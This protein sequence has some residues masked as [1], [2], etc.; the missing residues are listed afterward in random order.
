[1]IAEGF[2]PTDPL[3]AEHLNQLLANAGLWNLFLKNIAVQTMFGSGPNGVFDFDGANTY[4]HW[5]KVGSVYTNTAYTRFAPSNMTVRSGITVKINAGYIVGGGKL[6]VEGGGVIVL[7][8]NDGAAGAPGVAGAG[9]AVVAGTGARG[10]GATGGAGGAS[11]ANG[12]NGGNVVNGVGGN[13][14]D[15]GN[16]TG[17]H[18]GGGAASGSV[19]DASVLTTYPGCVEAL[20]SQIDSSTDTTYISLIGGG[21]GG[22]G[23]GGGTGVTTPGGGGGGGGA[24][25]LIVAFP[26]MDVSGT[27]FR[28]AGG[29]GGASTGASGGGGG[30]GG[31]GL[32]SLFTLKNTNPGTALSTNCSVAGGLGGAGSGGGG[33]GSVGAVGAIYVLIP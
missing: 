18:G 7:D 12:V 11:T 29:H 10:Y 5:T 32:I 1:M 6:T 23:G 27:A 22:G 33:S 14:G 21:A 26:E 8:G 9:G 19:G 24:G 30:G 16:A 15:G 31:G 17:L 20:V 2:D 3:A 25:T 13:G 28:A 4:T